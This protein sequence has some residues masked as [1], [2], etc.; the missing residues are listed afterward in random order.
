MRA[1][2]STVDVLEADT[3]RCEAL[4]L[5]GVTAADAE[6]AACSLIVVKYRDLPTYKARRR[7]RL[8]AQAWSA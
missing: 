5:V 3:I 2:V 4:R 6:S 7:R 8:Q 1:T